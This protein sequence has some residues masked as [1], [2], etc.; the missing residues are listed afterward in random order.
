ML[1]VQSITPTML[2]ALETQMIGTTVTIAATS[3]NLLSYDY[4]F[5]RLT[6]HVQHKSQIAVAN[7]LLRETSV[8]RLD[9]SL[10][11]SRIFLHWYLFS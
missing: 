3:F 5:L 4:D 8:A 9:Y 1:T 6:P 7:V 10:D 2:E 11:I